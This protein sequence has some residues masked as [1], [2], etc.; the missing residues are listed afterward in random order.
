MRSR[1]ALL[2]V[3]DAPPG[4]RGDLQQLTARFG[5]LPRCVRAAANSRPALDGL[6]AL[7]GALGWGRIPE[8]LADR[9]AIAIAVVNDCTHLEEMHRCALRRNCKISDE[10]IERARD[11]RSEDPRYEAALQFVVEIASRRGRI[12]DESFVAVR[13]AGY[14]D[15][16]IVELISHVALQTFGNYL[17]LSL[18]PPNEDIDR[19]R[20]KSA[21][22]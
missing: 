19:A 5:E 2:S 10:E 17:D 6:L 8:D 4:M 3:E 7:S 16:E 9:I 1:I 14:T 22:A 15:E 20:L 11:G 12:S 21:G 13:A 18:L